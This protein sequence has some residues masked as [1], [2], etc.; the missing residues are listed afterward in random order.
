VMAAVHPTAV[1]E[2]GAKLGAGVSVGAFCTIGPEVELG[3]GVTVAAHV[4]IAGRTRIG[5]R[6]RIHPFASL[7]QPPQHLGHK[8]EATVLSIG[9]DNIIREYA[10]MNTGTA[11]GD[12]EARVGSHCFFMVGIHVAHDCRIGDRVIMANNATLGGHVT[13]ADDV[14]I[15][16]LSAVHQFVRIGRQAMIGG[17]SGI[18]MDV[19]PFALATGP[20]ARLAGLNVVGLKRRGMPAAD[21]AAL[22]TAYRLVFDGDGRLGERLDEVMAAAGDSA[23]VV[24]LVE[25]I[26]TLSGR[27]LLYPRRRH[28]IA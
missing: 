17:M 9:T 28:G 1:V 23:P 15:G 10:T 20:R 21:I 4:A 13:I 24:E 6:S 12:G 19:I 5:A 11:E 27:R 3:D 18:G 14:V 8:G 25:F 7:G 26:R 22:R 2:H 16:G